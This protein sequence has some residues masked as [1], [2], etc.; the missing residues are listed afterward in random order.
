MVEFGVGFRPRATGNG[1]IGRRVEGAGYDVLLFSDTQ[2]LAPSLYGPLTEVAMATERLHIGPGVTNPVTRSLA[3]TASAMA[4]LHVLSRG[5]AICG[6]GRGD[7]AAE[8]AGI[9][10][11]TVAAMRDSLTSLS[12][13][14]RAEAPAAELPAQYPLWWYDP[15]T[16]PLLPL[17]VA[18]TGERMIRLAADVAQRVSFTVGASPDRIEWAMETMARRLSETG[19]PRSDIRVGAYI[20][21]ALAESVGDGIAL[22]RPRASVLARFAGS[23]VGSN[24][25][26][27]TY[28]QVA[29]NLNQWYSA[30]QHGHHS[31]SF[32]DQMSD[33]FLDEFSVVGPVSR[34]QEKIGALLE[35]GLDHLYIVGPTHPI[36]N[37]VEQAEAMLRDDLRFG[38]RVLS[39]FRGVPTGAS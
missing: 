8:H 20:N 36:D 6:I 22:V 31:V 32:K 39:R 16:L 2:N 29:R 12:Q 25:G 30:S 23:G 18:A 27:S 10:R 15:T 7:S 4:A 34:C 26:G 3:V 33:E 5:R 9:D 19:R 24:D 14:W 1:P 13:F 21:A 38:E 11:P 37:P 28:Q 17:D 35:L